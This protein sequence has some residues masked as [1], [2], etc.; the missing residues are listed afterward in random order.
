L[1]ALFRSFYGIRRP[2][3]N[4][5]SL[6]TADV[7]EASSEGSDEEA[8]DIESGEDTTESSSGKPTKC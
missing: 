7:S 1:N 5:I 4:I 3:A 6:P 8:F 2:P